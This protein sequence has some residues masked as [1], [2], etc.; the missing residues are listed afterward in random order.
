[1]PRLKPAT[2]GLSHRE[3]SGGPGRSVYNAEY[4]DRHCNLGSRRGFY[5]VSLKDR[6]Y[7]NPAYDLAVM[8]VLWVCMGSLPLFEPTTGASRL[9]ASLCL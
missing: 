6:R 3:S 8:S 5:T 9:S 7:S 4:K 1:M 2:T